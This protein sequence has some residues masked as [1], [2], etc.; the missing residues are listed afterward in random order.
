MGASQGLETLLEA[1]TLV[2]HCENLLF[3]LIG[4]GPGRAVLESQAQ[5]RRLTNIRFLP[6]QPGEDVPEVYASAD[7]HVVLLRRKISASV[8]SKVYSIMASGRP[9]VA[10]V[11]AGNEVASLVERSG[12]GLV[13]PPEEPRELADAILRLAKDPETRNQ[14]GEC[15]R[16]CVLRH[17]PK[18]AGAR[19]YDALIRR[20]VAQHEEG[21]RH[22]RHSG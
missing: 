11:P 21:R 1:A 7:L 12:A 3:L 15:G 17:Y 8:P 14:M 22:V 16:A 19:M 18:E 13:V 5:T 20:L 4:R 2:R 10:A 6:F 9:L